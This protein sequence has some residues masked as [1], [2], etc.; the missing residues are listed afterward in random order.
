MTALPFIHLNYY[1][2]KII[3]SKILF[4]K[5]KYILAVQ[6]RRKDMLRLPNKLQK[7]IHR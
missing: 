4:L 1:A 6:F 3:L 2:P 5:E 7:K